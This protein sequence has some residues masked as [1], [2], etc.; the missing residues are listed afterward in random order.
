MQEEEKARSM[1]SMQGASI[2]FPIDRDRKGGDE[3]SRR[4][5]GDGD[6]RR[7]RMRGEGRRV[8]I[9]RGGGGEK[10]VSSY[11]ATQMTS[12]DGTDRSE[13]DHSSGGT[14]CG[15]RAELRARFSRHGGEGGGRTVQTERAFR[16]G[17]TERLHRRRHGP[18]AAVLVRGREFRAGGAA[19]GDDKDVGLDV[20]SKGQ[21]LLAIVEAEGQTEAHLGNKADQRM[22]Q[23]GQQG[24][25][26]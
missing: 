10:V 17:P 11:G 26:P 16:P 3:R 7:R 14:V 13:R 21:V 9:E 2:A 19:K 18:Q 12:G 20:A 5:S 1:E 24:S 4:G 6:S 25:A 15:R 22:L 8:R 23:E